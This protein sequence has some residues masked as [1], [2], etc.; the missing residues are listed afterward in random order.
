MK[1]LLIPDRIWSEI[2]I[3][4]ITGL[5]ESEGYKNMIVITDRLNK[6]VV[7]DGLNDLEAETVIK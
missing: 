5:P 4:F 6:G 7:I 1:P 2:S 3:D